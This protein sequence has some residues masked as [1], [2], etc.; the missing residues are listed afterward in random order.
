MQMENLFSSSCGDLANPSSS[1]QMKREPEVYACQ[2]SVSALSAVSS[3]CVNST[4]KRKLSLDELEY[5]S[6]SSVPLK[7]LKDKSAY[8]PPC[9]VCNGPASGFHY[10]EHVKYGKQHEKRP[11]DSSVSIDD[12]RHDIQII[13][14]PHDKGQM[15]VLQGSKY[16][17]HCRTVK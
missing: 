13:E 17:C 2:T 4:Q 3:D 12:P 8:L 14:I 7:S 15:P 9:R 16:S 5:L 10:G 1:L 6:P 11:H